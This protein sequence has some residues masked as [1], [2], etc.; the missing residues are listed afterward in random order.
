MFQSSHLLM[1]E[2]SESSCRQSSTSLGAAWLWRK[3]HRKWAQIA[4][5]QTKP[6]SQI[7]WCWLRV[8]QQYLTALRALCS[9]IK[10]HHIVRGEKFKLSAQANETL[11]ECTCIF[12]A[13]NSSGDFTLPWIQREET[14]Q[15]CL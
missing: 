11:H 5:S 7:D 13:D 1:Y 8:H 9:K 14:A 12:A 10:G 2:Y 4:E 3:H 6:G 15:R